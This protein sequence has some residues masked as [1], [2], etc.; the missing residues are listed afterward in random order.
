M[1][2]GWRSAFCTSLP[3]DGEVIRREKLNK[4]SP[5]TSPSPRSNS[6]K[7]GGLFT[8]TSTTKTKIKSHSLPSTPRL[9]SH[10]PISVSPSLRCRTTPLMPPQNENT[11]KLQCKT[12]SSKLFQTSSSAPSSPK[13]P[14]KFSI[15][16]SG[17]RLSK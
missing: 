3:R 13:S 15:F 7:I 11:P 14:L 16:K 17:S 9:Q 12:K 4:R 1:G 8:T 2:T 5:S 6:R 10:H